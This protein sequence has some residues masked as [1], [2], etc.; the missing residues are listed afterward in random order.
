MTGKHGSVYRITLFAGL[1]NIGLNVLLIPAHG[2]LGAA[3]AT[4]LSICV[5]NTSYVVAVHRQLRIRIF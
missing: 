5:F 3:L 4:G 1:L 2:I